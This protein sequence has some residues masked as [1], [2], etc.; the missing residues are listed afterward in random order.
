M[1][2]VQRVRLWACPSHGSAC[3][4]H[5]GGVP[6]AEN[7]PAHVHVRRCCGAEYLSVPWCERA[8]RGSGLCQA[9]RHRGSAARTRLLNQNLGSPGVVGMW[10]VRMAYLLPPWPM[11]R[12]RLWTVCQ[13]LAQVWCKW[14]V[15]WRREL[16]R[17]SALSVCSALQKVEGEA[18]VS[19]RPGRGDRKRNSCCQLVRVT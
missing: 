9:S 3:S 13:V 6:S 12:L 1:R 10:R 16:T 19:A 7:V 14:C 17:V 8:V 11:W 4:S 18:R 5:A 15:V 2:A